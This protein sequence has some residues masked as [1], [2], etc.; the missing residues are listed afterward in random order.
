MGYFRASTV[1]VAVSVIGFGTA[2]AEDKIKDT[3]V[4]AVTDI[5]A[6]AH[7]GQNSVTSRVAARH[8]FKPMASSYNTK[9]QVIV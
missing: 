7:D 4:C 1:A 8:F 5:H 9:R 2:V 6:C 3:L